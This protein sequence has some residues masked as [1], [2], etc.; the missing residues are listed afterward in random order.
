MKRNGKKWTE[1]DIKYLINNKDKYSYSVIAK[2][3]NRTD[4]SVSSKAK[5]LGLKKPRKPHDY[6]PE[7]DAFLRANYKTMTDR[8]LAERLPRRNKASVSA[9]RFVLGL[10]KTKAMIDKMDFDRNEFKK[11][12]AAWNKGKKG[13]MGPNKT[14]FKKG[15]IPKNAKAVGAITTRVDKSGKSYL[16][17]KLPSERVMKMLHVHLWEEAN[18]KTPEG[19]V[20]AFVD[21][22]T[23]NCTLENLECI[24]RAEL[25]RRN[26]RNAVVFSD[27][28][29]EHNPELY[30]LHQVTKQIKKA[31]K[32]AS[33]KQT[34]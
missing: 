3:L 13:Y 8:Q 33:K 6:T 27:Y 12:Q 17:I 32:K 28:L 1:S 34:C 25:L 10:T 23:M 21:G 19:H 26:Q 15:H 16:H 7:E 9:R 18:G 11:G 14:S 5:A 2:H 29:K 31:V 24:S 4:K 30:E 20:V 22:N